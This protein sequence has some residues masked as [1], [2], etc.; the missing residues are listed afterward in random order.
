M[1]AARRTR[2]RSATLGGPHPA[3][4]CQ[5]PTPQRRGDVYPRTSAHASRDVR[6]RR[7]RATRDDATATETVASRTSRARRDLSRRRRRRR[8]RARVGDA[9]EDVGGHR[10]R[11]ARDATESNATSP[12]TTWRIR[13]DGDEDGSTGAAA[14]VGVGEGVSRD[15]E[16]RRRRWR[17]RLFC[18][19]RRPRRDTA[20]RRW[21]DVE[22]GP[23]ASSVVSRA[24]R[25]S[26]ERDRGEAGRGVH[27]PDHKGRSGW[28]TPVNAGWTNAGLCWAQGTKGLLEEHPRRLTLGR[29]RSE[30][31]VASSD[32]RRGCWCDS[33][34]AC[35]KHPVPSWRGARACLPASVPATPSAPDID[36]RPLEDA[37]RAREA[38]CARRV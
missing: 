13:G 7:R 9:P 18:V 24:T 19:G 2:R 26:D 36:P 3:S 10:S 32:E 22:T 16:R 1:I 28:T 6:R 34:V 17:R 15:E 30:G 29:R 37:P 8:R 11:N 33:R 5:N 38:E 25:G 27:T 4:R 35:V 20:R 23:R 31:G 14:G 21:S 12:A